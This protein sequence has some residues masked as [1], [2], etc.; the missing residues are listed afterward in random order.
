MAA[1]QSVFTVEMYALGEIVEARKP[2]SAETAADALK[3]ATAWIYDGG[4]NA[5]NFRVIDPDGTI[6]FD[7]PVAALH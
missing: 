7:S 1:D 6:L 4:H 5:T 2:F 3:A